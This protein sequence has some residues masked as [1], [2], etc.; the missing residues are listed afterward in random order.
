MALYL[1]NIGFGVKRLNFYKLNGH[2]MVKMASI[3][4]FLLV[5]S[6]NIKC[7]IE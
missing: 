6:R 4:S 5:E 1:S 2:Y 7:R 3:N